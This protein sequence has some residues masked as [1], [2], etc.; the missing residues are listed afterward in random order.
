MEAGC[1]TGRDGL[2]RAAKIR[3]SNGLNTT[4]QVV[5]LYPLEMLTADQRL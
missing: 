4:R 3:T 5:K 1:M 2:T